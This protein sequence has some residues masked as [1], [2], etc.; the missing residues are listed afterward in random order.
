MLT[1][2]AYSQYVSTNVAKSDKFVSPKA[3]TWRERRW[4]LLRPGSGHVFSTFPQGFTLI[5]MIGVLA[6]IGVLAAL[7]VP[8]VFDI[9]VSSKIDALA[10]ALKT[11]ET[12]VT[13]YY[14][15]MGTVMPL[16]TSG[17]PQLESSGDSATAH[18]L[19][20]RLTLSRLDPL[21]LN[22]NLWP[23]FMGP[24]LEKFNTNAPPA[25]GT[26]MYM[27]VKSAVAYGTPV[28]GINEGWDLKGDDGNSDLPSS[29]NVAYIYVT[30]LS[31]EDF[32]EFDSIVDRDVGS[33]KSENELRGRAKWDPINNGTLKLYLAHQ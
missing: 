8:K 13:K 10:S 2:G 5:E 6:V 3:A 27:P 32:L 12:A 1:R 7:I 14:T 11:Y 28:T 18:S 4:R 22:S 15:D 24:Y 20:A 30:G 25:L 17:N 29:A 26:K 21:V 33:S 16:N 31:E 23:R 19:P 9:I